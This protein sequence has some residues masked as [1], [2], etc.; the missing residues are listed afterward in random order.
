MRLALCPGGW[1]HLVEVFRL[2]REKQWMSLGIWCIC[3][4][5]KN[6]LHLC[7]MVY[8]CFCTQIYWT[9]RDLP[10]EWEVNPLEYSSKLQRVGLRLST[11][12]VAHIIWWGSV[13]FIFHKWRNWVTESLQDLAKDEQGISVRAGT[14]GQFCDCHA[15]N[16]V[17]QVGFPALL[18]P[19]LASSFH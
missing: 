11:E 16:E 13:L 6:T 12:C 5:S 18:F 17:C 2:S 19:A 9:L 1:G 8:E 10:V 14:R 3:D 7:L 15:R 4:N